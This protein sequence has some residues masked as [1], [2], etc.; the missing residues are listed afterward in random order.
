MFATLKVIASL[1]LVRLVN[2][3]LELEVRKSLASPTESTY[4]M[5]EIF[6]LE[7]HMAIASMWRAII[8]KESCNAN[9]NA[10]MLR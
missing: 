8:V 9:T 4:L 7:I 10:P 3:K 5:L 6:L 1:S 2:L